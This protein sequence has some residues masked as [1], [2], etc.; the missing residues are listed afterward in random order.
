LAAFVYIANSKYKLKTMTNTIN[1]PVKVQVFD[2]PYYNHLSQKDYR[3][4]IY[5]NGERLPVTDGQ[6]ISNIIAVLNFLGI[7]VKK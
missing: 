4:V 5:I 1:E 7:E 3:Q 6:Q 2:E